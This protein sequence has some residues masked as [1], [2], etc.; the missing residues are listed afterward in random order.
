MELNFKI[1]YISNN[2]E[3][4]ISKIKYFLSQQNLNF[5]IVDECGIILSENNQIIGLICRYQ[6]NL[7]CLAI[8][9]KHQNQN[10]AS[11]LITYMI[12]KIYIHGFNEVFVFT[13]PEYLAIFQNLGFDL[14]YDNK[15]F[16]FLT[17]RYDLLLKYIDYLKNQKKMSFNSGAIVM[18]ANPFTKGHEFLIKKALE[19]SDLVYVILVKEKASF[20]DYQ[21]RIDMVK[22]GVKDMNNV[23]VLEGSNYLVSKNVFPSYFL[24]SPKAAIKQQTILDTYIFIN[25]IVKHLDI[26]KRFVGEEPYSKTTNYYNE[27]LKMILNSNDLKLII[28]PRL[29]YNNKIISATQIRK[30]FVKGDFA[31]ISALVPLTTLNYLQKLNYLEYKNNY[32]LMKLVDKKY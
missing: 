9:K 19:E 6:N 25:Y 13:K 3:E 7:K 16:A 28:F 30:L 22:L 18:N 23:V 17:N 24:P 20:F 10:M 4:Y 32:D 14:I 1:K 15:D 5:D 2:N 31:N 27:T 29:S 12:E 8:D 11:Y 21:K 26:K